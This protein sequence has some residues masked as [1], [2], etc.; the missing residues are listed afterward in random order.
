MLAPLISILI[1]L[2]SSGSNPGDPIAAIERSMPPHGVLHLVYEAEALNGTFEFWLDFSSQ[3]VLHIHR[4]RVFLRDKNGRYSRG[5]GADTRTGELRG[6]DDDIES[7]VNSFFDIPH[8]VS[9]ALLLLAE[10]DNL[11]SIEETAN[12]WLVIWNAPD[13]VALRSSP[14]GPVEVPSASHKRFEVSKAGQILSWQHFETLPTPRSGAVRS[15]NFSDTVDVA[16][17]V[18]PRY[19]DSFLDRTRRPPHPQIWQLSS[20]ELIDSPPPDLFTRN[21][22]IVRAAQAAKPLVQA[23]ADSYYWHTSPRAAEQEAMPLVDPTSKPLGATWS[24]AFLVGGS[25]V[26]A[27]GV[28]AWWR[29]KK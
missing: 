20:A 29:S 10:R 6:W 26:M 27:L 2:S 3:C 7:Y 19:V 8:P 18:I 4:S 13:S 23:F 14:D 12:G 11:T 5:T 24:R 21:G 25:I 15:H 28:F 22:A 17:I 9:Q 16:G 1:G